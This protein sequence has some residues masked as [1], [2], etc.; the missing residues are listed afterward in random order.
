MFLSV[1]FPFYLG[2]CH[3][4]FLKNQPERILAVV[5]QWLSDTNPHVRRLCSEGVRPKLPW[6]MRLPLFA[7]QPDLILPILEAA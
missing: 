3:P 1:D 4:S 6:G 5:M 7:D 2:V